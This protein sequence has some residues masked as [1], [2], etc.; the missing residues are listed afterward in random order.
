MIMA[1]TLTMKVSALSWKIKLHLRMCVVVELKR[2][3]FPIS[4]HLLNFRVKYT[5]AVDNLHY[6]HFRK[7]Q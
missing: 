1:I 4:R 5:L 7:R 2:T 6:M 3:K